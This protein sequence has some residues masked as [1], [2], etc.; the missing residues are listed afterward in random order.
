[1]FW[2]FWSVC[3][4][5][6]LSRGPVVPKVENGPEEIPSRPDRFSVRFCIC[7]IPFLYLQ[8]LRMFSV[9]FF[10]KWKTTYSDRT[11]SI[12]KNYVVPQLYF[13]PKAGGVFGPSP[14]LCLVG[15]SSVGHHGPWTVLLPFF[16]FHFCLPI[17]KKIYLFTH[18]LSSLLLFQMSSHALISHVFLRFV[19]VLHIIYLM[20]SRTSFFHCGTF[21]L[22]RYIFLLF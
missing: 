7:G 19:V 6:G 8:K 21:F 10:I 16:S 17:F 12:G 15:C 2:S 3:I 22:C 5:T 1:M 18:S 20:W 11:I 9:R 4:A 14:L 13:G